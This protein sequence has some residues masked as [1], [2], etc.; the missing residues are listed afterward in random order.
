MGLLVLCSLG[1]EYEDDDEY[2]KDKRCITIVLVLVLLLVLDK[3]IFQK[4]SSGCSASLRYPKDRIRPMDK[5]KLKT[6]VSL[7]VLASA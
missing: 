1:N 5:S 4:T 7:A 6:S 2:E 3:G